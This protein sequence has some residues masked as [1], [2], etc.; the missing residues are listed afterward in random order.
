MNTVPKHRVML[1][2]SRP[3]RRPPSRQYYRPLAIEPLEDRRLLSVEPMMVRDINVIGDGIYFFSN[4]IDVDG[5]FF[6]VADDGVHGM[7]GGELWKSDGTA[8]G[9]VLVKDIWPGRQPRYSGPDHLTNVA[10]TLFFTAFDP[11]RGGQLWK[12]DGTAEGTV[13]L[14]AVGVFQTAVVGDMLFFVGN[15]G[16]TGSELWKS[17]GTAEGT[18]LVKD[19]RTDTYP[20]GYPKSSAPEDLTVLDGIV[21]FV[22]DDGVHGR[23]L[24]RSD[25]TADGTVLVKDIKPGAGFGHIRSLTSTGGSLF[26]AADDGVTGL[27]LWKS[28]GTEAGTELVKDIFPGELYPGN[29]FSSLPEEL[30]T[31]GGSVFFRAQLVDS[32]SELW[33]SDGTAEGTV[34]V[35]DIDPGTAGSRPYNL[36]NVG[37]KLFYFNGSDGSLWQSD[38]TEAGTVSFQQTLTGTSATAVS[39]PIEMGG[40]LFFLA[41]HPAY[42]R[43][44]WASD[45]TAAGTTLV[46]DINPGIG[47]SSVR[48]L[49]EAGGTLYFLADDGATGPELWKSDG[50]AEGTRLVKDIVLTT[51]DSSPRTLT[52][53]GDT[54]FFP[55]N[56]GIHG[57]SLWKSDGTAEGTVLVTDVSLQ[58]DFPLIERVGDVVF[59]A[60]DDG[61]HGLELWKSDGTE[62]GT[63]LVKDIRPGPSPYPYVPGPAGSAPRELT[64]V[65]DTLFFVASGKTGLGEL[66]KSD[67]TPEGTLRLREFD[68]IISWLTDF[69]GTLLFQAYT[70]TTGDELWK[71][72]GT[73]EGTVLVKDIQ[74]GP[75]S[76]LPDRFTVVGDTAFF[77]AFDSVHGSELWKTDG[78][79]EGTVLVKDIGRDN[80]GIFFGPY[81][82]T[83]VGGTLYFTATDFVHG[84]ELWKSDG[85][86]EGTIMVK[87]VA[88]NNA[89][90]I[91]G[92]PVG[93]TAVGEELYFRANDG[94]TGYELWKSDGTESGTQLIKEINPA[95]DDGS[96]RYGGSFPQE[97]TSLGGKVF[98]TANDGVTGDE[99]WK[100]DGTPEG[101]VLV[102]D[103]GDD[104]FPRLLTAA[105]GKLF[106]TATDG[107]HGYELW[108]LAA[109]PGDTNLDGVVDISDLNNVRNNFGR[110]GNTFPGD[111]TGDGV[112]NIDDL[113]AVR[114]NFGA[115]AGAGAPTG[116]RGG[117]SAPSAVDM[118]L[119]DDFFAVAREETLA[120]MIDA[121]I[122]PT[123]GQ[124]FPQAPVANGLFERATAFEPAEAII[125]TAPIKANR[126]SPRAG[127]W[128]ASR[129]HEI[130]ADIARSLMDLVRS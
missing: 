8:E 35:K 4:P 111:T 62:A 112:V 120:E 102:A 118:S 33:M 89:D 66:W 44:L 93:L 94:A 46:N 37:G 25:G 11:A 21:Y 100:T 129:G 10:G 96:S 1:G 19:I 5:T 78:T 51:S 41:D 81:A 103:I 65:G 9:T 90:F 71:S 55:A 22:A 121:H 36:T 13:P 24:W 114:N 113:N 123:R 50:T 39:I 64:A 69:H 84:R 34:L 18:V 67:G 60:G 122:G 99:L 107:F 14:K 80:N 72:D 87:D 15:D 116:I 97:F 95:G 47:A 101:T 91:S 63:V 92:S 70:E 76:S 56:D 127:L 104:S 48:Y 26:F 86:E 61:V 32:G 124:E 16:R 54:V 3:L 45:G 119:F 20:G 27:E 82:L 68:S 49:T 75:G 17:D 40:R 57:L 85:T 126:E 106:F 130:E 88:P 108:K 42:G 6:F 31:V 43:E 110:A 73:A 98:F 28:D 59:F 74:P 83:A 128:R 29:P 2:G 38:G 109:P 12:S 125:A 23:E 117:R 30:T 79:E 115:G 52:P 105:G 53:L 77:A 7:Y 58:S